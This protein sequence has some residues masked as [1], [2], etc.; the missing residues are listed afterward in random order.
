M[1][2]DLRQNFVFAQYLE[3]KL[4]KFTKFYICFHIDK[5][6][7]GIITHHFPHICT[8]VMALVW[9]LIY[10]RS[11]FHLNILRTNGQI[12]TKLYIA[13]ILTRFKLGLLAVSFFPQICYRVMALDRCQ[14][15]ISTQYLGKLGLFM[16]EK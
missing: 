1:A 11:L 7:I 2:L 6:Y 5:I 15:F 3:N 14:N 16:H 8:R 13:I 10:V 9:P 12:M 4:T